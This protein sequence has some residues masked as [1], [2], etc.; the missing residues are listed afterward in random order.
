MT[1]V[2]GGKMG[3]LLPVAV[4]CVKTRRRVVE[5]CYGSMQSKTLCCHLAGAVCRPGDS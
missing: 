2:L 3:P 1:C 4:A 5:S